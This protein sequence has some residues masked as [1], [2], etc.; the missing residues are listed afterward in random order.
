[1][2]FK[3]RHLF[4]FVA[5]IAVAVLI[6][7]RYRRRTVMI[8]FS[9]AMPWGFADPDPVRLPVE[10]DYV[11]NAWACDDSKW[12]A[13]STVTANFGYNQV[14]RRTITADNLEEYDSIVADIIL[15]PRPFPWSPI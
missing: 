5:A 4:V 13:N 1:M 15:R 8:D 2:R 6:I 10:G 9:H 7:D 12:V 3:L 11:L 14:L